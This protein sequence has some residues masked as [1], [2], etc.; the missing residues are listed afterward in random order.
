MKNKDRFVHNLRLD[1]HMTQRT[2]APV[3][4][5][6]GLTGAVQERSSFDGPKVLGAHLLAAGLRADQTRWPGM[7][8]GCEKPVHSLAGKSRLK[9]R[10][11]LVG[12]CCRVR[13]SRRDSRLQ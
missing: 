3:R 2:L 10:S 5:S 12:S 6:D 8:G 4:F 9:S 13:P 1:F 11:I 7:I